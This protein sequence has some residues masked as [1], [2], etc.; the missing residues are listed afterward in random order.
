MRKP[1]ASG[2]VEIEWESPKILLGSFSLLCLSRVKPALSHVY[3]SH[4]SPHFAG[5]T[6]NF[7]RVKEE[8]IAQEEGQRKCWSWC[9]LDKFWHPNK[10]LGE[11]IGFFLAYL[12][13]ITNVVTST[14]L[15]FIAFVVIS[16]CKQKTKLICLTCAQPPPCVL[17][18]QWRVR[19]RPLI[20]V[21]MRK[22]SIWVVAEG[23]LSKSSFVVL[24]ICGWGGGPRRENILK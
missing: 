22:E 19:Q 13:L 20:H 6:G 24:F 4:S 15:L 3:S 14:H 2:E 21:E 8:T 11:N 1:S 17:E 18:M 5:E 9:Y 12:H 7:H 23:D 10:C 16:I